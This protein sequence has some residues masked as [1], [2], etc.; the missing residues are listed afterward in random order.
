MQL[1]A[2]KKSIQIIWYERKDSCSSAII[3][4]SVLKVPNTL[5]IVEQ[6]MLEKK[7]LC[8]WS[9]KKLINQFRGEI[10]NVLGAYNNLTHFLMKPEEKVCTG[11]GSMGLFRI[12]PNTASGQHQKTMIMFFW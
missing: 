5:E 7:I 3:Y 9:I 2:F 1:L 10:W 6:Y 12:W 11:I 8:R 4:K